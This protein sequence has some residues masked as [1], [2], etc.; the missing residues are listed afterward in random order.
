MTDSHP[1]PRRESATP[2]RVGLIGYGVAGSVFHAPLI[3]ANTNYR[4]QAIVTADPLRATLARQRHPQARRQQSL[5]IHK[6]VDDGR[7][8]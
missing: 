2:I 6:P 7:S 3:A 5:R 8:A 1:S 4:L